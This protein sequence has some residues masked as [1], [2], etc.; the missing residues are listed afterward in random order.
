MSE[1]GIIKSLTES[2]RAEISDPDRRI[3]LPQ[4][5]LLLPL[6]VFARRIPP[7]PLPAGSSRPASNANAAAA[8]RDTEAV[9]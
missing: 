9:N 4:T 1:R 5:G 7:G 2:H 3:L 6:P 8:D